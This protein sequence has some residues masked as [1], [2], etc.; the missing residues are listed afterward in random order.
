VTTPKP[1]EEQKALGKALDGLSTRLGNAYRPLNDGDHKFERTGWLLL[2]AAVAMISSGDKAY[3]LASDWAARGFPAGS[4]EPVVSTGEDI[5]ALNSVERASQQSDEWENRRDQLGLLR[6][7]LDDN[8]RDIESQIVDTVRVRENEGRRDSLIACGNPSCDN[9]VTGL[10]DDRLRRG[11][12]PRCYQF[13][14]R[15]DR[16]WNSRLDLLSRVSG[17]QRA[18]YP[19]PQPLPCEVCGIAVDPP[20]DGLTDAW[21]DGEITFRCPLHRA[22]NGEQ[23]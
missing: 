19:H 9:K 4:D 22:R 16:E 18:S 7:W 12:C 3:A 21:L 15:T 17:G 8:S 14:N 13:R 5:E 6:R 23:G 11:R 20:S 10:G 1:T 2:R